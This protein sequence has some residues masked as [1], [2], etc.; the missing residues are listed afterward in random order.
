MTLK[1]CKYDGIDRT[2]FPPTNKFWKLQSPNFLLL[3]LES[4]SQGGSQFPPGQDK[5]IV[6]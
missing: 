5:E 3:A 2:L 6:E 1:T 4:F